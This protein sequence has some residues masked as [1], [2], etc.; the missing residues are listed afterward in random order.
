[1]EFICNQSSK[2]FLPKSDKIN[3][4]AEK[5]RNDVRNT[6]KY[7]SDFYYI[8]YIKYRPLGPQRHKIAFKCKSFFKSLR[9]CVHI[10]FR[11]IFWI[12]LMREYLTIS[13]KMTNYNISYLMNNS[14]DRILFFSMFILQSNCR[15][16]PMQLV[17]LNKIFDLMYS[18]SLTFCVC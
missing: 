10:F 12:H 5:F 17:Y 1:M 15:L 7:Q 8:A 13:M 3:R 6:R 4:K 14:I 11:V 9:I 16:S 18:V 2:S